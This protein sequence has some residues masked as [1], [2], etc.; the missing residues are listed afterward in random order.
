MTEIHTPRKFGTQIG[1]NTPQL[2]S[3][4][5]KKPF[6]LSKEENSTPKRVSSKTRSKS[7]PNTKTDLNNQTVQAA[8]KAAPSAAKPIVAESQSSP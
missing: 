3:G 7:P 4:A 1:N 2:T 8:Q 6:F 5:P